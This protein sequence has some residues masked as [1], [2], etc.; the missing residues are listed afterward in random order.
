MSVRYAKSSWISC[1]ATSALVALV[2]G[3]LPAEAWPK[4]KKKKKSRAPEELTNFLLGPDHSHWLLGAISWI[5]SEPE[6]ARYLSLTSDDEATAFVEE[7]WSA[8]RDGDSVWPAKQPQGVFE[9]RAREADTY[10][11][12][13]PR[14]GRR[15]ARGTVYILFGPAENEKFEVSSRPGSPAIEVWE[16]PKDAPEGLHGERPRRFYYFVRKGEYTVETTAPNRQRL[17]QVGGA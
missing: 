14:P 3:F 5:A 16:Y 6:V 10:Y 11:T 17:R 12:E 2:L 7:F 1:A 13:G 15:S 4:G 9:G 8:R